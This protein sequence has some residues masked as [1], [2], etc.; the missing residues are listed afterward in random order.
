MQ[1]LEAER[2]VIEALLDKIAVDPRHQQAYRLWAAPIATRNF[3]DGTTGFVSVDDTTV[4]H[5]TG[6][7][8]LK[9][10]GLVALSRGNRG[11][12][13]L[14]GLRNELPSVASIAAGD[15]RAWT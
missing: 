3:D 5:H 6:F 12:K 7:V 13:I 4:Q 2:S 15:N 1:L 8:S 14:L 11:K 9:G 10:E